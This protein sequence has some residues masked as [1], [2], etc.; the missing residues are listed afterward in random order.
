MEKIMERYSNISVSKIATIRNRDIYDFY[1]IIGSLTQSY[2][3]DF[4]DAFARK[5]SEEYYDF[6]TSMDGFIGGQC[7]VPSRKT[8]IVW[9]GTEKLWDK[10]Y[11]F[12]AKDIESATNFPAKCTRRGA[13]FIGH[14][15]GEEQSRLDLFFQPEKGRRRKPVLS[16]SEF[17]EIIQIEHRQRPDTGQWFIIHSVW[18]KFKKLRKNL[19]SG[20]L[21]KKIMSMDECLGLA[22]TNGPLLDMIG[23]TA[24]KEAL[25]AKFNAGTPADFWDKVSPKLRQQ[26]N[27]IRRNELHL[28]MI[29]FNQERSSEIFTSDPHGTL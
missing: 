4:I 10:L 13:E 9:G 12:Y 21:Q 23:E 1:A 29:T 14:V 15:R 26:I 22:H 2:F 28:P 25:N 11:N 20:S 6:F 8:W 3:V 27:Q 17:D 19:V 18:N 5:I 7:G 24:G 16:E